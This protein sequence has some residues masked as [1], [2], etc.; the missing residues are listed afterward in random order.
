MLVQWSSESKAQPGKLVLC[1]TKQLKVLHRLISTHI[2]ENN[3]NTA[4]QIPHVF[5]HGTEN[6]LVEEQ[7]AMAVMSIWRE[8][9][10]R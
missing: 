2:N 4:R 9:I 8:F 10:D 7:Y 3:I 6:K 5:I 1:N